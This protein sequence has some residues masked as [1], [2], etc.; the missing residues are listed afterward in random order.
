MFKQFRRT[1][2]AEMREVTQRDIDWVQNRGFLPINVNSI[3]EKKDFGWSDSNSFEEES[4]WEIEGGEEAYNAAIEKWEEERKIFVSISDEDLKNGSPKLGDMIARNPS[5][6]K[7]Q[8]LVAKEYFEKNFEAIVDKPQNRAIF[9]T[10]WTPRSTVFSPPYI[11]FPQD[12]DPVWVG[13]MCREHLKA[14]GFE[15]YGVMEKTLLEATDLMDI[16][17]DYPKW[18]SK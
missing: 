18:N 2:I 16:P 5:N 3:P 10:L 12:A 6:H 13:D 8:W 4:G 1:N 15:C 9:Q 7:D 11:E 14:E 17:K